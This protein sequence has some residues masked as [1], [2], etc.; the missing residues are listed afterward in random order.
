MQDEQD[1]FDISVS[2]NAIVRFKKQDVTL[3]AQRWKKRFKKQKDIAGY[4]IAASLGVLLLGASSVFEKK[5]R[6][7]SQAFNSAALGA[8]SSW[9][10]QRAY[11]LDQEE[12]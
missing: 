1:E 8:L 6:A 4:N 11:D 2:P 7:L 10:S 5:N 3:V 9:A 12:N